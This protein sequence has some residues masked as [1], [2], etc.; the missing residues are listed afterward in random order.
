MAAR[1][2]DGRQAS[3]GRGIEELATR[4]IPAVRRGVRVGQ[5]RTTLLETRAKK[6]VTDEAGTVVGPIAED[7]DGAFEIKAKSVILATGGWQCDK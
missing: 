3:D 1:T 5:G 4:R 7:A 2:F 6:L